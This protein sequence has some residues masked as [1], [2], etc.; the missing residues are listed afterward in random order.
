MQFQDFL[1]RNS[2]SLTFAEKL[3][4]VMTVVAKEHGGIPLLQ[5]PAVPRSPAK[6]TEPLGDD[7][8]NSLCQGL[9]EHWKVMDEKLRF[10]REV[11]RSEPYIYESLPPQKTDSGIKARDWEI[12]DARSMRTL[13]DHGFPMDIPLDALQRMMRRSSIGN[14]AGCNTV[15]KAIL[16]KY[17]FCPQHKKTINL[18]GLLRRYFPTTLD[19]AAIALFLLLQTGWNKESV[20]EI[21]GENFEHPLTGSIDEKLAVVFSE[22]YRSQGIG[23]PYESPSQITASSNPDDPYSIY[24]LI[25]LARNLSKPLKGYTF[26]TNAFIGSGKVRNEL[27]LFLRAWGDWFKNGSRHSSISIFNSYTQ[28]I[29]GFLKKY[30]VYESGKRLLRV[31]D[32]TPRLRATWLKHQ[33]KANSL[34]IITSHLKHKYGNTTDV[35]YNSSA[36]AMAERSSRLRSELEEVTKRLVNRQFSGLLGKIANE[37]ASLSIKLF[38]IPGKDRPMWGCE[39]QFSP[40]WYG[41]QHVVAKGEK[42]YQVDKCIGCSRVR[43]YDDSLPYLMER[44]GHIDYELEME[45]EDSRSSE[46]RWEKQT[47]EYLINDCHDEDTITEAARYRRRNSPLLPHDM[48]SLRL[49]FDEMDDD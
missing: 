36:T 9:M 5:F 11:E 29:E 3:K 37:Q 38:T 43:I 10:R 7:A 31:S 20:I 28:G 8:F 18:D 12:D 45:S 19:Q 21:D 15:V 48:S 25:V 14:F 22:K 24:S 2:K 30:P 39:D 40:D 32:I 49:I 16:H 41:H 17:I 33:K 42:C 4:S 35:H 1:L 47:L 27:Y 44:L 46:L 26:D 34:S 23:A 6:K 13:L